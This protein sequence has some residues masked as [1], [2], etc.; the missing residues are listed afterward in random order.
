MQRQGR[1]GIQYNR[2]SDKKSDDGTRAMRRQGGTVGIVHGGKRDAAN[3][4]TVRENSK[5]A[6]GWLSRGL[7]KVLGVRCPSA[8]NCAEQRKKESVHP[9]GDGEKGKAR[10]LAKKRGPRWDSN[11]SPRGYEQEIG[12]NH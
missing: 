9:I 10:S 5:A 8:K 7:L 12:P 11:Q 4:T 2:E 1:W 3:N 6:G